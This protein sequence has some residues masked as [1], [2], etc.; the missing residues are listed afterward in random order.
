MQAGKHPIDAVADAKADCDDRR[1]RLDVI[2]RVTPTVGFR[3]GR[4][5]IGRQSVVMFDM[6]GQVCFVTWTSLTLKAKNAAESDLA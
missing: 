1:K 6:S 4:F 5:T 3:V 2:G